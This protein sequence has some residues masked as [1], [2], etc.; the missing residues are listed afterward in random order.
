[1]TAAMPPLPPSVDAAR[2]PLGPW[3][4]FL[5]ILEG[6]MVVGILSTHLFVVP[7]FK[8]IFEQQHGHLPVLTALILFVTGWRLMLVALF[9]ILALGTVTFLKFQLKSETA[10][11]W[12]DLGFLLAILGFLALIV[13]GLFLPMIGMIQSFQDTGMKH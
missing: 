10:R 12:L 6:V 1:M 9:W 11:A 13:V 3:R 8:A 5:I 4:V 7:R 2:P